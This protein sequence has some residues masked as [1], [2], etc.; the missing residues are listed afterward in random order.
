[1]KNFSQNPGKRY[2]YFIAPRTVL[3]SLQ[4]LREALAFDKAS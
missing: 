1:M 4:G 3:L 2:S